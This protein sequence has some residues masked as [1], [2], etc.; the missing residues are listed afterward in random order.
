[1]MNC[2]KC[3]KPVRALVCWES[4][5]YRTFMSKDGYDDDSKE[6]VSDGG[7]EYECSECQEVIATTEKRAY[8]LLEG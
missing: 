5:E 6:F 3:K 7:L 4:G 2:P 1:M 8:K